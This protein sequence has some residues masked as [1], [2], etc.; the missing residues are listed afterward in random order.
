MPKIT[1]LGKFYHPDSGGIEGVT[2]TLAEGAIASGYDVD[3]VCFSKSGHYQPIEEIGGVR[4]LRASTLSTIKSQPISITYLRNAIYCGSTS[5]I[6]HIHLP[7]M[8]AAFASLLIE[9]SKLVIHWHSDVVGKGILGLLFKKLE[10]ISLKRA[11]RIIATTE[12]YAKSS[13]EL[14]D[15]LEK[16]TV[17]PLGCKDFGAQ[18]IQRGEISP[19]EEIDDFVKDHNL[20]LSVGRLVPYKGF[21][22]LIEAAQYLDANIVVAIIGSGPLFDELQ[23][24]IDSLGLARLVK[25]FG[26]QGDAELLEFYKRAQIFCLPSIDRSEAFG[27]VLP[28][29]MSFG[30]PIIA[31]KISGSGVPWV[32]QHGITG[33]NVEVKNPHSIANACNQIIRSKQ[34][35]YAYSQ[36]SRIRYLTEFKEELEIQRTLALYKNFL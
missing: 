4:V 15:Y 9:P 26:R 31:T 36:G 19:S 34:E 5:D 33:L 3:V 11:K 23:K 2:R 30:L 22:V 29:A 12:I 14:R 10:N 8:L 7:N 20:I 18:W 16:V 13:K 24:K 17:I 35:R 27:L 28:E 32:N 6:V 25:L 21:D 1:H